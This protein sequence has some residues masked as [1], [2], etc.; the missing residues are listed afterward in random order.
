[1]KLIIVATPGY[2]MHAVLNSER[3]TH[4]GNEK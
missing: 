3:K 1:M 4:Q 2:E